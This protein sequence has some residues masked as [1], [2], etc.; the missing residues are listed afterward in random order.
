MLSPMIELMVS[1]ITLSRI[2][3]MFWLELIVSSFGCQ[4]DVKSYDRT[5]G[6]FNR[7]V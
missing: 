6:E 5:D 4:I 7:F 1:S 3:S 2:D